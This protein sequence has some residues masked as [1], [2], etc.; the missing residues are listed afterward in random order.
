MKLGPQVMR[1]HIDNKSKLCN[2]EETIYWTVEFS[3][4]SSKTDK[5]ERVLTKEPVSENI[6][7]ENLIQEILTGKHVQ[8]DKN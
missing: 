6:S 7:V 5:I 8:D 1:R 3:I 2:S 4:L